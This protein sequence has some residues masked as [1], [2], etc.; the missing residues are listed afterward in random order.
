VNGAGTLAIELPDL[1]ATAR[2]AARLADLARTG[3]AIGLAGELGVG[4]TTFARA[5]INRLAGETVEVP[6]PT[7][8]LVL[9][10][11]TP[12][13]TVWHFDLYRVE[14]AEELAELGFDDALA[15]GIALVE[16]P[17]RL[18]A[19]WPDDGLMLRFESGAGEA[20]RVG[21]QGGGDWPRRLKSMAAHV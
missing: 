16:W 20:R 17:E 19:A 21:I 6:S 7:F 18:G 5:F 13:V 14:H 9:S 3:D 10:Y 8:N 11:P 12:G 1:A 15:E 4:K 2:L